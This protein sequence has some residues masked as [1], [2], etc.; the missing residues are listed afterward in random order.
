MGLGIFKF[1]WFQGSQKLLFAIKLSI[2]LDQQKIKK[3]PHNRF[4]DNYLTNHVV[5]FLQDKIKTWRVG[6]LRVCTGYHSF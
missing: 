3:I 5:I 2:K 4:G 1:G 6:A